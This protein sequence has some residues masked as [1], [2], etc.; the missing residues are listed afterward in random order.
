MSSKREQLI[1]T[2][3]ELFA[4]NGFHATGIDTILAHAGVAKKTLYSH[5]H[6]KE[7]LILA[8]L[9][10]HDGQFRNYLMKNVDALAD[11]PADKLLAIFD[12]V[13]DWFS[14]NNF[15][16]CMFI[17]AIGEYSE[18][19]TAI[20]EVCKEYKRLIRNYIKDLAEQAGV[21]D[22]TALSNELSILLE[23]SIVTAQVSGV[24]EEV[25]DTAK[26]VASTLIENAL[27]K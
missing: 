25:A 10:Q 3:I 20:R 26:R 6:T 9:R 17:N 1:E 7:E 8:A 19:E 5:F 13:K 15:Y 27:H 11:A 4:K 23:G 21:K 22:A 18:Q 12:V 16:G 2:A 24:S 14:Q